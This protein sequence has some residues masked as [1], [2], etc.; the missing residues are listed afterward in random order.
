MR[1]DAK[2]RR[3][4]P[5]RWACAAPGT[6]V[7]VRSDSTYTLDSLMAAHEPHPKALNA[8]LIATIRRRMKTRGNI[9]FEHVRGHS[10]EPGNERAD[11]LAGEARLDE[12]RGRWLRSQMT[13]SEER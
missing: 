11:V 3:V 1:R 5:R 6:R 7:V 2:A 9:S 12:S 10:G 8:G 4:T 13:T